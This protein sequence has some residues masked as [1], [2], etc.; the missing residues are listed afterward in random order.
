MGLPPADR[1]PG[2]PLQPRPEK[3][4]IRYEIPIR[5]ENG[6]I[7]MVHIRHWDNNG[8]VKVRIQGSA[9]TWLSERRP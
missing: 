5:L 9:L 6:R 7:G 1:R 2:A 8:E 4:G 3:D